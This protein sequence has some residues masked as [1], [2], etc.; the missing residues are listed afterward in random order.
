[1]DDTEV[2]IPLSALWYL[3]CVPLGG[4]E[5]ARLTGMADVAGAIPT[6]EAILPPSDQSTT[7]ENE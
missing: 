5:M 4:E 6:K 2:L 7:D 3:F 1:M